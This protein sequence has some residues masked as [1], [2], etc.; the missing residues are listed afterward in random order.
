MTTLHLKWLWYGCIILYLPIL[1]GN[2]GAFTRVIDIT[3]TARRAIRFK[4]TGVHEISSTGKCTDT[5]HM[6]DTRQHTAVP[7]SMYESILT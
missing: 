7:Q 6:L 2:N 5:A 1:W 3:A 4:H